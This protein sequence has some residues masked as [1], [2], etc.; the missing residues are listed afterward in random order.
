LTAVTA[1]GLAFLGA[2]LGTIAAYVAVAGFFQSNQLEG[3]LSDLVH[4]I[5]WSNLLLIVIAMPVAATLIGWV[6]AGREPGGIATR[7][8]E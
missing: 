2:L 6:L 8:M 1:G 4:H 5:P 7:P 3:G